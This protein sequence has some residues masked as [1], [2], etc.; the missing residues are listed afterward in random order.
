M[1]NTNKNSFFNSADGKGERALLKE[2]T[3]HTAV[4]ITE[5]GNLVT[6]EELPF[7][8]LVTIKAATNDFADSNKLGQGGFG[9]VYKVDTNTLVLFRHCFG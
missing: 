6:S 3:S 7:V 9:S 5:D 2:L 8:D 4:T 1:T